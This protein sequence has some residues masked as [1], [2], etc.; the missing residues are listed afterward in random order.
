MRTDGEIM[1]VTNW[2][3]L[4]VDGCGQWHK[5]LRNY[6]FT[7]DKGRQ[8]REDFEI[9]FMRHVF[10]VQNISFP[11]W[12]SAFFGSWPPLSR[13]HDHTQTHHS[14]YDSSGW[15]IS[16]S[17][18]PLLDEKRHSLETKIH[19]LARIRSQNP[20]KRGAADSCLRLRDR[21]DRHIFTGTFIFCINSVLWIFQ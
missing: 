1:S 5:S 15:V 20:S 18:R 10:L 14:W 3:L 11:L 17:H 13:F 12:F 16:P 6:W 8:L 2:A 19:V 4:R 9:H 7:Y 21:W